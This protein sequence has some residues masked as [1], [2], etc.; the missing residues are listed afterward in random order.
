MY[1]QLDKADEAAIDKINEDRWFNDK[2]LYG[3]DYCGVPLDQY[4]NVAD[5]KFM[6]ECK[7][8]LQTEKL[9]QIFDQRCK[10]ETKC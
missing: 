8:A 2:F 5:L 3:F 10:H 4:Y 6:S 7:G 9:E 1:P